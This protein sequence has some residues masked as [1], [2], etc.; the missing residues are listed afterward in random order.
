MPSALQ[1]RPPP[2]HP[3]GVRRRGEAACVRARCGATKRKKIARPCGEARGGRSRGGSAPHARASISR[4]RDCRPPA[5]CT[6]NDET[7]RTL[8]LATL[9]RPSRTARSEAPARSKRAAML[10]RGRGEPGGDHRDALPLPPIA[11]CNTWPQNS[12]DRA[13]AKN[14]ESCVDLMRP[15]ASR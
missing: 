14:N 13:R 4:C 10:R 9:W 12:T 8:A 5:V 1:R 15:I 6:Q 3:P 11:S 7:R 2:R